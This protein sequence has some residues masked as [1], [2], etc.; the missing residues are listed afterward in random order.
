MVWGQGGAGSALLRRRADALPRRRHR[1]P[2]T[3]GD[4]ARGRV[5]RL[6]SLTGLRFMAALAVFGNHVG[7]FFLDPGSSVNDTLQT[8]FVGVS[9]FFVLSGFVLTW[10]LRPG[11][12]PTAFYR[13]R[14]ARIVP[15]H[16]VVWAVVL[17]FLLAVGRTV[18]LPGALLSLALLQA[19]H[20]SEAVHFAV[21]AVAWTLSVEAFFYFVFPFVL[22]VLSR[23]A[24]RHRRVLLGL[25]V[26][27][28][29][30][31]AG[32]AQALFPG[33]RHWAVYVLPVTR[34]PEFVIGILLALEVREGRR[35]R[36]PLS[37]A[38][39]L[40]V[41]AWLLCQVAPPAFQVASLTLVP[42]SVLI[43]VAAGAD[44]EG[45]P[46][47]ARHPVLVRLGDW[48]FAFYLVHLLVLDVADRVVGLGGRSGL[49]AAAAVP[50]LLLAAVALSAVLFST[51]ERPLERRLRHPH[52]TAR[53]GTP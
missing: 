6:P 52:R 4:P 41:G 24:S 1:P 13:R 40:A 15:N 43:V 27:A 31:A 38:G 18:G 50:A 35:L 44:V 7:D 34:L 30:A 51:V 10:S 25:A 46:S 12:R 16:I 8:G 37:A 2:E 9:F 32:L 19:W 17:V 47:V 36:L 42:F 14:V 39:A 45:R 21:N 11:D 53:L 23:L 49:F 5:T 29:W 48:S 3:L 33:E 20:P 28:V 26:L 22:P